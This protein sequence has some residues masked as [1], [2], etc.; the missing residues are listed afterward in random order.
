MYICYVDE[1]G[2]TAPVPAANSPV[3]PVIVLCALILEQS[4]I[5][6]LTHDF[7]N[8]KRKFFPNYCGHKGH[9]LEDMMVELKGSILRREIR[10]SRKLRRHHFGYLDGIL[11]ILVQYHARYT[12][13]IWVKALGQPLDGTAVYTT[14]I[15]GM[16]RHFQEFLVGA[17]DIGIMVADFR[18]PGLNARVSHSIFTQKLKATG[19]AFDRI[20]ELPT[21]G[22]SENHAAIQIDDYLCSTLLFPIATQTYCAAHLTASPH[23]HPTDAK[24]KQ[25]YALLLRNL[26]YRYYKNA[27]WRGG[28]SVDDKLGN[29]PSRLM[30]T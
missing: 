20:L 24:T 1:A 7:L 18:T 25:R 14:T 17:N 21:F 13:H 11:K 9:Q 2:D 4:R 16:C 30:V 8:L 10:E 6:P 3:Q 5:K 12:A 28:I 19:D 15:Q 29:L 27:M 26:Q 22:H 23:V